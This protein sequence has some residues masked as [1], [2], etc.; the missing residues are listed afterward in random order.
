MLVKLTELQTNTRKS[1]ELFIIGSK[2]PLGV[3]YDKK[4][5]V[6]AEPTAPGL[7]AIR[8]TSGFW[9]GELNGRSVGVSKVSTGEGLV[10]KLSLGM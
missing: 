5:S 2:R 6:A 3:A 9:G 7:R 8:G 4:N 10:S 1:I